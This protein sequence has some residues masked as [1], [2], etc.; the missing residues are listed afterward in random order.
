MQL[1]VI[2]IQ[3]INVNDKT[4]SIYCHVVY[5][6]DLYVNGKATLRALVHFRVAMFVRCYCLPLLDKLNIFSYCLFRFATREM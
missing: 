5:C 6:I 4:I 2:N 3:I 1:T